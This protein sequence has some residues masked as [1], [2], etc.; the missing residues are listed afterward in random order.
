MDTVLIALASALVCYAL[1]VLPG[2]AN[3]GTP[4]DAGNHQRATKLI[5]PDKLKADLDF[6]LKTIEDVHPNMYAYTS[7]EEFANQRQAAYQQIDRAMTPPEFY[8]VVAPL[9]VSLKNGHTHIKRPR[10]FDRHLEG[11]GSV[12]P[13][14]L[15]W[16]GQHAI[17]SRN[18]GPEEL[19][20]GGTVLQVNGEDAR[21]VIARFARYLPS[22]GRNA[23]AWMI[24]REDWLWCWLWLEYG[25]TRPLGLRIREVDGKV[26]DYQVKPVPLAAMGVKLS[27]IRP[28]YRYRYIPEYNVGVIECNFFTD[29][30]R[31]ERFLK[32][33]FAEVRKRKLRDLIIDLRKCRGGIS[34][35]SEALFGYLSAK[36]FKLKEKI[37]SKVSRQL[38]AEGRWFPPDLQPGDVSVHLPPPVDPGQND[39]RFGGRVFVLIG[40]LTFS[41][42]STF[43]HGVKHYGIGTLVGEETLERMSGYGG[44]HNWRLPNSGLQAAIASQHTVNTGASAGDEGVLPD[45]EVKQKPEDTAE[46]IDTVL[47]FTLDLIQS[48]NKT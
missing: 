26:N 44:P 9:V 14:L 17:L 18:Y 24:A 34:T 33:T 11:G 43:A 37:A 39:L 41:E 22:E 21:K 46:G 10:E 48:G 36:P 35:A 13:L 5:A 3:A 2:A 4:A 38:Q 27:H 31:F 6:L 47:Q 42:G 15:Y 32:K 8:R 7:K 40:P 28:D 29:T 23:N 45:Y 20:I 1:F 30:E 19:P 16:D 25:A 12:F